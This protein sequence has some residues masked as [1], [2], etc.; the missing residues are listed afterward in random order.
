[1]IFTTGLFIYH[2]K[3]VVKNITTKEELKKFFNNIFGNPFKR[4][5]KRNLKEIL[6]PT[7][8]KKSILDVLRL[9]GLSRTLN[10]TICKKNDELIELSVQKSHIEDVDTDHMNNSDDDDIGSNGSNKVETEANNTINEKKQTAPYEKE[11]LTEET[12]EKINTFRKIRP[13]N[14][15]EPNQIKNKV[16]LP[17]IRNPN[18]IVEEKKKEKADE[19]NQKTKYQL[20][21]RKKKIN[22]KNVDLGE[23]TINLPDENNKQDK[24]N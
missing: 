4:N 3:L 6:F 7:F 19:N 18:G 11:K 20:P 1:M 2:I 17:P 16:F 13:L 9:E 8:G 24:I 10:K 22:S 12:Q 15:Q 5:V 21:K 14:N 23:I